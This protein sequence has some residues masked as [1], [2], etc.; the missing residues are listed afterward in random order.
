MTKAQLQTLERD[1]F[2]ITSKIFNPLNTTLSDPAVKRKVTISNLFANHHQSIGD[3]VRILDE[4]FDH[5]VK[6][7]IE[8]GFIYERRKNPQEVKI[9][10]RGSL[11][12]RR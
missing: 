12:R 2:Q 1:G 10:R 6:V 11:F 4:K 8:Q 9:E 3:I 5:V 7:L